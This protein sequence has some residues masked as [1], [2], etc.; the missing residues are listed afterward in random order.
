MAV[1]WF[2]EFFACY[3]IDPQPCLSECTLPK[4]DYTAIHNTKHRDKRIL[5]WPFLEAVVCG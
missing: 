2:D 5:L 1:A 3:S 4:G